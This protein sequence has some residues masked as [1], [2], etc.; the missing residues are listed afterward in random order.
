MLFKLNVYFN[1]KNFEINMVINVYGIEFWICFL[2]NMDDMGDEFMKVKP[3]LNLLFPSQH[4][5][6]AAHRY[7][8]PFSTL[9]HSCNK[10]H[11]IRTKSIIMM[12]QNIQ[13]LL[14]LHF[15]DGLFYLQFFCLWIYGLSFYQ[16]KYVFW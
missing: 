11:H 15:D 7:Y 14:M 5:V 3:R 4:S 16:F 12:S 9:V 1:L 8:A 10:I 2:N 13:F 6:N